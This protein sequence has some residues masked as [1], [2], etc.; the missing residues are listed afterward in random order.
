[1]S[2]FSSYSSMSTSLSLP[3]PVRGPSL[4]PFAAL[5]GKRANGVSPRAAPWP[6]PRPPQ[7][8][9]WGEG[10]IR[11]RRSAA[12]PRRTA[13]PAQRR[14]RG[15]MRGREGGARIMGRSTIISA[16]HLDL[17]E[18]RARCAG[19]ARF[20]LG[21][22]PRRAWRAAT[23]RRSRACRRG[24]ANFSHCS[25]S[26][27]AWFAPP[28]CDLNSRLSW[29]HKRC[30]AGSS[31]S[32]SSSSGSSS[33]GISSSSCCSH[34]DRPHPGLTGSLAAASGSHT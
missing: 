27:A 30:A 4:L 25:L 7:P 6:S 9:R 32:S 26:E 18:P 33:G 14:A 28:W 15:P 31:S 21:G 19:D 34:L 3:A 16:L 22:A 8:A 5:G 23:P 10:R 17:G 12:L 13:R 20:V 11:R 24:A 1:M 2:G 29:V